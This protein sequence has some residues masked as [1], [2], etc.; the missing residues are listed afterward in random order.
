MSAADARAAWVT[1]L[2]SNLPRESLA[3]DLKI[4]PADSQD[5]VSNKI[6]AAVHVNPPCDL[7]ENHPEVTTLRQ[8]SQQAGLGVLSGIGLLLAR[9]HRRR[10]DRPV[11]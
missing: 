9:R 3:A 1:R 4:K 8:R 2:E 11:S 7:L 10:R 6:R 5:P